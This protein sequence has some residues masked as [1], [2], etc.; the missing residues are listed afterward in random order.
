MFDKVVFFGDARSRNIVINQL[1]MPIVD[2]CKCCNIYKYTT[3]NGTTMNIWNCSGSCLSSLDTCLDVATALVIKFVTETDLCY[4]YNRLVRHYAPFATD[5]G[6]RN[7]DANKVSK[8][9]K[10]SLTN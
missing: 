5:R 3:I 10:M 9:L 4:R 2:K 1:N 6:V 8:I 7:A